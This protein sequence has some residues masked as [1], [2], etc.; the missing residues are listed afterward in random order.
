METNIRMYLCIVQN[1]NMPYL[2][3]DLPMDNKRFVIENNF[4]GEGFSNDSYFTLFSNITIMALCL[5]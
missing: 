4:R 3:P 1:E 5:S 2:N